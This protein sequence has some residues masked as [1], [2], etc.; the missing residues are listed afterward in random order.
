MSNAPIK[1]QD[2]NASIKL[3]NTTIYNY[4]AENFGYEERLPDDSLCNKYD[5]YSIKDLKKALKELKSSNSDLAEIRYVSR[6]VRNK[7]KTKAT[8]DNLSNNKDEPFNHDKFLERNFWGYVKKVVNFDESILPTF[9]E[10]VKSLAESGF[11]LH[12][13][14]NIFIKYERFS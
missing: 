1:S 8:N 7:L 5:N 14:Q 12:F 13:E 2:L 4:F 3:L 10:A 11:C 6:L 9:K